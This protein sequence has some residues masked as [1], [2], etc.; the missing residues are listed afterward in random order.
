[1]HIRN[2]IN[3][4]DF[5]KQVRTCSRDVLFETEEGDRIALKSTLSQYIFCTIASHPEL[6]RSGT[7]RFTL[8]KDRELLKEFLCDEAED[9]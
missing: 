3:V 7:I 9:S 8:E 2:N 5:L 6:L 4:V 1:M